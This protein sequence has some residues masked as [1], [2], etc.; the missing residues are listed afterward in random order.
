MG[1]MV[2]TGDMQRERRRIGD[3]CNNHQLSRGLL[4]E[5]EP[6]VKSYSDNSSPVALRHF[7]LSSGGGRSSVGGGGLGYFE[8]VVSKFDTLVGVAIKYGV[9]VVDIKRMNGLTTDQ[10][11]FALKSLRIPLRGRHP[12]SLIMSNGSTKQTIERDGDNYF[13]LFNSIKSVKLSSSCQLENSI[14]MNNFEKL[15]RRRNGKNINQ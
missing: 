2:L 15:V 13:D 7:S 9:E 12:P 3:C 6:P 8:H 4:M 14:S 5:S 10:Q 11:M 1:R